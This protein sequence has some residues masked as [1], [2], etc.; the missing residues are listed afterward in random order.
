MGK[1]ESV[2]DFEKN[3]EQERNAG[4][5][6]LDLN[7][8]IYH[9]MVPNEEEI[10]FEQ[11]IMMGMS[12]PEDLYIRENAEKA[13]NDEKIYCADLDLLVPKEVKNMINAYQNKMNEF[14]TKNLDQYENE[15]TINNFVQNLFLPKKITQRPNEINEN[16]APSEFPPQLWEKIERVQKMGGTMGFII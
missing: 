10:V 11:K 16:E 2:E 9:Q 13:K 5:E 15:G 12:L 4:Q 3:L 7:Q 6:M 14:I 1:L 8:R